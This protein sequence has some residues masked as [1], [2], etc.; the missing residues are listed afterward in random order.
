MCSQKIKLNNETGSNASRK[1]EN[2]YDVGRTS[3]HQDGK[4]QERTADSRT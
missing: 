1:S 2:D 4:G 3:Y